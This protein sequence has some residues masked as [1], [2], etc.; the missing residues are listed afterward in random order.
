M[1][2]QKLKNLPMP[3][4]PGF[5]EAQVREITNQILKQYKFEKIIRF[6]SKINIVKKESCFVFDEDHSLT[7]NELN[8][9][10]LMLI[11]SKDEKCADIKMQQ[12]L[13]EQFKS[14]ASV[15]ILIH[16]MHEF[17]DALQNGSSF[18]KSIYKKGT[19]LH[20]NNEE[21][22]LSPAEGAPIDERIIRREK[23]WDHWHRLSMGFVRGGR[24]FIEEE[25]NSGL[26]VFM[27]HQALQHC[28]SGMIRVLTGYRTN[29][30][31]LRRLLQL[32]DLAMPD[33]SIFTSFRATPEDLRLKG[34]LLKG[35][36]DARYDDTFIVTKEDLF[37][38]YNR[39]MSIINDGNKVC[40]QR[41]A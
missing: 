2:K 13:E 22:F 28:Y 30:N 5:G 4:E 16:R 34:V 35:F 39:I 41:I 14:I 38:L 18:F 26:A 33:S 32:I 11:P 25:K 12:R 3:S 21:H 36:S 37:T 40:L 8:S 10:Y 19:I 24:F 6:G 17:N 9:Y 23:Y 27:L 1:K 7:S 15:T 20:D 31:S 29:S